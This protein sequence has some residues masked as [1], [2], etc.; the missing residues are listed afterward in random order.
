M[1]SVE[2]VVSTCDRCTTEVTTPL[3]RKYK[4]HPELVLPQ[5]WLHVAGNTATTLVFEMDL[6]D[7]CKKIVMEVAGKARVV[8]S[9]SGQAKGKQSSSAKKAVSEQA[10][11]S[12]QDPAIDNMD[13]PQ[14]NE[15]VSIG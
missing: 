14:Q 11:A 4:K 2:V 5:G 8:H 7:E 13:A 10:T 6:C 1:A 3:K 15:L 9:T 12:E